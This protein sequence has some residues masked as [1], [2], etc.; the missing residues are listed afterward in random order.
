MLT[1]QEAERMEIMTPLSLFYQELDMSS[2]MQDV[3][4]LGVAN[5]RLRLHWALL[6][7]NKLHCLLQCVRSFH[8]LISC[9]RSQNFLVFLTRSHYSDAK[10]LRTMRVASK[11]QRVP[12]LLLE[13]STLPSSIIIL[14]DM[15]MMVQ[16]IFTQ[17][18]QRSK[19]QIYLPS[20]YLRHLLFIC[21]SSS[22]VGNSG[23][24]F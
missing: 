7:V 18:I 12:S 14:G 15:C 21:G 20:L 5:F 23:T 24:A 22:W 4:S 13:Q 16:L 10:C 2:C 19:L 1:L 17:L 8:F 9:R 6:R 3:Q 11:L